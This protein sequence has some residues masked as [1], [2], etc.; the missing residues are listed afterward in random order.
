MDYIWFLEA[1]WDRLV[2]MVLKVSRERVSAVVR[3][4]RVS[5]TDGGQ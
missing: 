3:G 5:E 4:C 2:A 1:P